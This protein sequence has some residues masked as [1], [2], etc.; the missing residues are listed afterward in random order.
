MQ[1]L[2]IMTIELIFLGIKHGTLYINMESLAL[3][4]YSGAELNIS[5]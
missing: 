1:N 2:K 4:F 5:R 3:L